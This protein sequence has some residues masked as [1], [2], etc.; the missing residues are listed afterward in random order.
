ME[1]NRTNC[2]NCGAPLNYDLNNRMATCQYCNTEY[3]LD[4][5]GRIEE[6]KVELE[7]M[8]QRRKFY[9][10]CVTVEPI[11]TEMSR[12]FIDGNL[13]FIRGNDIIKLELI[14]Y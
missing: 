2:K 11:Y 5:L 8:G 14:S 6:Y 9:I 12:N 1:I 3:H 10:S 4:N 13:S 7:I